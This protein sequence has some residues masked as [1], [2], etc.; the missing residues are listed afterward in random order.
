MKKLNFKQGENMKKWLKGAMHVHTN[1]SDGRSDPQFVLETY[2]NC[3]YDFIVWTDHCVNWDIDKY[4]KDRKDVVCIGGVEVSVNM[5]KKVN[6][7]EEGITDYFLK[8]DLGAYSIPHINA[9]GVYGTDITF[10]AYSGDVSKTLENMIDAVNA[11]NGIPM[12]NHPNWLVG[13]SYWEL[14]K[15][16]RKFLMEIGNCW[17]CC[18]GGNFARES[19]ETQWDILL[20]KGMSVYGTAT[21]DAH[22]YDRESIENGREHFNK[23]YVC[24]YAEK[25]EESILNALRCGDFYASNG[26]DIEEYTADGKKMYVRIK[27]NGDEKYIINFKG[28]MGMPLKSVYGTEAEYEFTGSPDEEY[29]RCKIV[30]NALQESKVNFHESNCYYKACYTQP[31][32]P[33]GK[34]FVI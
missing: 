15:V 18:I 12:I 9:L 24:V 2:R 31:Y 27:P 17:D 16:N 33:K 20:S 22:L 32:F 21:D 7:P 13:M 4:I 3:G 14:L 28:R 34:Q 11:E 19:M 5:G 8:N 25:N 10:D 23:G 26:V 29:V 6:D 30:S 1:N